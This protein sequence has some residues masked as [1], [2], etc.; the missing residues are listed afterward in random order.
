M[1]SRSLTTRKIQAYFRNLIIIFKLFLICGSGVLT[2]L[3]LPKT[4]YFKL[5]SS[6][7][8][9]GFCLNNVIVEGINHL[10]KQDAYGF[11]DYSNQSF[12][13][14]IDLG[15]IEQRVKKNPWVKSCIIR[16][17]LP[18][19]IHIKI[20]ERKPIGIWQNCNRHYVIDEDGYCIGDEIRDCERFIHLI[21][22]V[23]KGANLYAHQ[24][25][26]QIKEDPLLGV[27]VTTA[28]RCGERR[29]NI[30][31]DEMIV[32][33]PERNFAKAWRYLSEMNKNGK[34]FGCRIKSIDLR[35][36][37]KFYIEYC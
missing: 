20:L 12:I 29:W 25:I 6:M 27:K 24:L 16:R 30:F 32:Q 2:Y 31:L 3:G 1:L 18:N 21:H 14:E 17:Q 10:P 7:K 8:Q 34:L 4:L 19:V 23:G 37:N 9:Q 5:A 26:A 36:E 22:F 28:V 35:N 33:M 11:I 13:F 15:S